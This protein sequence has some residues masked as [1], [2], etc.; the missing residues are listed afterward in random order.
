MSSNEIETGSIVIGQDGK[1]LTE[2]GINRTAND[3]APV[4]SLSKAITAVCVL[5]ALEATG[6]THELNVERALP[7]FFSRYRV[8]DR[9]LFLASIGNLITHD[10]GIHSDFVDH[11]RGLPT[12]EEEQKELQ[13]Q[14]LALE[15]LG[16]VPGQNNFHYSNGN[17]L[18]LGLVIEEVT[19]EPYAEYCTEKVL[20]PLG[21]TDAGLY[22]EWMFTSS[23][24]GWEISARDYMTFL[25]EYFKDGL[26]LGV[27]PTRFQPKVHIGNNRFYGPGV[28][29]R[30]TDKGTLIWHAGGWRWN[31]GQIDDQFGAYFLMLDSGLA[32]VTNF[33]A[34]VSNEQLGEFE[35]MIWALIRD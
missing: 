32:I 5:K 3:P 10:S 35:S 6:Q 29:F 18:A 22:Q 19:G 15:R 12:F 23:F 4:A 31:D 2:A 25:N 7:S 1:Q 9:R 11:Y 33:S 21:I 34:A 17:Y 28:L 13:M 14:Y 8:K 16:S 24:G 26:L 20:R 27:S 30:R